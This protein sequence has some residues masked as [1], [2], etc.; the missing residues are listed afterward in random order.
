[1]RRCALALFLAAILVLAAVP[2]P[3]LAAGGLQFFGNEFEIDTYEEWATGDLDEGKLVIDSTVGGGA[4]S[5]P[6]VK[7]RLRTP[8]QSFLCLKANPL[9]TW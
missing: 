4:I 1:M 6:T 8:R 9:S 2:V 7:P 5:W 3:A